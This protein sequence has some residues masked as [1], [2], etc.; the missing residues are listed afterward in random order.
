LKTNGNKREAK[1]LTYKKKTGKIKHSVILKVQE[2]KCKRMTARRAFSW[3][4]IFTFR[5]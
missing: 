1:T 2:A 5:R 4:T 3:H